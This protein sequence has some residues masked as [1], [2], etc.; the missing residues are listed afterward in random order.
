M[1]RKVSVL[2]LFF[3]FV[4]AHRGFSSE[5]D[6]IL[7]FNNVEIRT[8]IKFVGEFTKENYVIDPNVRGNITVYSYKPVPSGDIKTIF[9]AILNLYGF[10]SIEKEGVSFVIPVSEGRARVRAVNVGEIPPDKMED[11]L[12]QVVPLQY[13]PPDTI[14]QVLSP[15]ITKGGQITVDART[16]SLVISDIGENVAKLKDIIS[17]IDVPSAP[18]KEEIIIRRLQNADSEEVAK[19]LTQVLSKPRTVVRRGEV[20]PIQPSVVAAKA[21]NSLIIHAEPSDIPGIE[22]IIKEMDVLT[23]QVLIEATIIEVSF[24][25]AKEVGLELTLGNTLMG[26]DYTG[27]L[28]GEGM[29][30]LENTSS[31]SGFLEIGLLHKDLSRGAIL[32]M[33]EKDAHFNIL[34]TPQIMTTDNYEAS[35]NVSENIPYLKETRFI[36]DTSGDTGDTIRSY[37]YKDVG[38]IL[39][40]TPQI[41]QDKYVRLKISQEVTKVTG[42]IDGQPKTAKRAVETNLIVPNNETIV[43]GGLVGE[44][45]GESTQ[46]VPFFGDI[47][48]LGRLFR[49]EQSSSLK[50]NLLIFITP[51]IVTT[52]EE[53]V[54]LTTEKKK[55]IIGETGH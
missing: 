21:T 42:S 49:K 37:D 2:M 16:N 9:K 5:Q 48:L 33:F 25:K 47:P 20:P 18:G 38:I 1:A 30:T 17:K 54:E 50:T 12:I 46:K 26:G 35:I 3:F 32:R 29:G 53:A 19:I 45:K 36:Q 6:F 13:Y 15:Y 24:D 41:S 40:I 43:L 55:N 23:G 22:N 10:T 34:S 28:V 8:F 51:R 27:S 52:F 39:K 7:N 4:F 11:F 14:S 31:G 44:D